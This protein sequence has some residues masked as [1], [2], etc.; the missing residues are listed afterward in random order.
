MPNGLAGVGSDVVPPVRYNPAVPP[1]VGHVV[2][3]ALSHEPLRRPPH[4]HALARALREARRT[5]EEGPPPA[6]EVEAD[7]FTRTSPASPRELHLRPLFL[8]PAVAVL[9]LVVAMA[10]G[11]FLWW[12]ERLP[13]SGPSVAIVPNVEG[14]PLEQAEQVV[15]A[16]GLRVE[17][18][19]TQPADGPPGL[20]VAQ[21][22]VPGSLVP[23][24]RTVRVVL[25][26]KATPVAVI[27]VPDVF[28]LSLQQATFV[29]EGAG[30]SVGQIRQA[31]DAAVPAGLV[32]EQNPRAGVSVAT[33]TAVDLIISA[34]PVAGEE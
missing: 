17:V 5:A 34:G 14:V 6:K 4:G 31:H 33:G 23:A 28:G 24:D 8:W 19:G 29:L 15:R 12:S 10:V 26:A 18:V 21:T 13:A 1:A 30:L 11:G 20:V 32:L 7:A 16:Q 27:T 22:P 25:S 3:L 9:A 2:M